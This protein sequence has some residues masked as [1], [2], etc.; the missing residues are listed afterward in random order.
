MMNI[1]LNDINDNDINK[2]L[3][4][5]TDAPQISPSHGILLN[6]NRK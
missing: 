2:I 4:N 3:V 1:H 6:K 5:D